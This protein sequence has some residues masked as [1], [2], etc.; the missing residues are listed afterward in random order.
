MKFEIF[1]GQNN[2]V[3]FNLKAKNGQVI[4]QSQGYSNISGAKSGIKSVQKN[5]QDDSRFQRKEAKNGKLHFNLLSGNKQVIA[6]SQMYASKS[7]MEKGIASVKKVA[8]E[9]TIVD[10]TK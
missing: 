3:Y 6:S 7:T 8:P 10:L 2:K 1:K 9:A 4:L 5:A